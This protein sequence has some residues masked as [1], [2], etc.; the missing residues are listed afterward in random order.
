MAKKAR[1]GM[2]RKK[3]RWSGVD[4]VEQLA[5]FNQRGQCIDQGACVVFLL[6][7]QSCFLRYASGV[8]SF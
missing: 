1:K 5:R 8:P 7:D 4:G 3:C 6:L 2:A